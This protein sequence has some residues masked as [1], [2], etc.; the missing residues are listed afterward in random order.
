MFC[1]CD[2]TPSITLRPKERLFLCRIKC[3]VRSPPR[4]PS[5][6]APAITCAARAG[7]P[8]AHAR[9]LAASI[10]HVPFL[11]CTAR[12][13]PD[14]RGRFRQGLWRQLCG[15]MSVFSRLRNGIPPSRDDC[16]VRSGVREPGSTSWGAPGARPWVA[17]P[18]TR[19]PWKG[20]AS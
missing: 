11:S 1:F 20:L 3:F 19:E 9:M 16:Q 6:F 14:F 4:A 17:A 15:K 7:R 5:C 18:E 12:V 13:V 8:S 10:D 2:R